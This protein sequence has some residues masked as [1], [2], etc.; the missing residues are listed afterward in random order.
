ML[1]GSPEINVETSPSFD[2]NWYRTQTVLQFLLG[3]TILAGLTGIA[4]GGWLSSSVVRIGSAEVTYERF[5]RKTVPFRIALRL[6]EQHPGEPVRLTLSRDLIERVA[7]VRS[8]PAAITTEAI[9]LGTQFVF[10]A[11]ARQTEIVIWVRPDRHGLFSW[12]L[13]IENVGEASL[14]QIIYP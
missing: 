5:A 2:R 10:A 6:V 3:L 14:F 12:K 1:R 8:V 9:P 7:I 13:R 4:G 11:D